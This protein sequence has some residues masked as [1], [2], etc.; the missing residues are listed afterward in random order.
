MFFRIET[1]WLATVYLALSAEALPW[2]NPVVS[3][4]VV[5]VDG[6]AS[7]PAQPTTIYQTIT[8]S[9]ASQSTAGTTIQV[10]VVE[11]PSEAPSTSTSEATATLTQAYTV[12][13]EATSLVTVH[14]SATASTL[15]TTDLSLETVTVVSVSTDVP[16]PTSTSYY[17]NGLWHTY[18]PVKTDWDT[19][20][21]VPTTTPQWNGTIADFK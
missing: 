16:A 14:P 12:S 20:A 10:T 5:N 11:T 8:E 13:V 4:S 9:A 3:Y 21:A 7:T 15:T 2:P 1:A 18:Y 6:G 17:D 19:R